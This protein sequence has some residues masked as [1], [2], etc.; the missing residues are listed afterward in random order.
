[1]ILHTYLPQLLTTNE[2]KYT[3]NTEWMNKIQ[4][5]VLA[6]NTQT[7]SYL[8]HII[9]PMSGRNFD[10]KLSDSYN[11][12]WTGI[13]HTCWQIS[14]FLKRNYRKVMI[15]TRYSNMRTKGL[16]ARTTGCILFIH[17]VLP[18]Y[19]VSFVVNNWGKYVWRITAKAAYSEHLGSNVQLKSIIWVELNDSCL[20]FYRETI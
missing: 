16:S 6:L 18:V 1:M 3:G 13:T 17:S 12:Q 5:V 11:L 8:L 20:Q 7:K 2:T 15:P 19:F 4:P 10:F 14:L 9:L